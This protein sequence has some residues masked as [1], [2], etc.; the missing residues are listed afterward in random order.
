[1]REFFVAVYR[2][3]DSNY[4]LSM[5]EASSISAMKVEIPRSWWSLA[6]TRA[7]MLSMIGISALTQGTKQPKSV[8]SIY[9]TYVGQKYT[10]GHLANKG[11]FS[12]HVGASDDLQVTLPL[13]HLAVICN[14]GCWVHNFD[15]RVSALNQVD[16][17]MAFEANFGPVVGVIGG[18]VAEGGKH[19]ELR[20]EHGDLF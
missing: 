1:M 12:S 14:A 17:F 6:P 10:S 3:Y 13:N 7:M 16:S 2:T 9:H 4:T 8:I 20:D 11:T 15:Q 5:H 19:I 18:D